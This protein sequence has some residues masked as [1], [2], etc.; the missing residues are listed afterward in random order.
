VLNSGATMRL[1]FLLQLGSVSE[2]V[3]VRAQ[4]SAIEVDSTRVATSLTTKLVE[5][6]PLVVTGQIRNVFNLAVIAPEVKT[7]NGYRI[8]GGQGSG[9]EM[10]MD[11]ISLTSQH[12]TRPSVRPSV[13][14]QWTLSPNSM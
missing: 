8:G 4:A 12:S 1:D 9:W 10:T 2:S 5:D 14:C 6:L 13:P 11:G 3:E 7:G